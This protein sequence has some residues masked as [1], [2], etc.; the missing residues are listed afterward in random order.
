MH[1]FALKTSED[2]LKLDLEARGSF[3][4]VGYG[5]LPNTGRWKHGTG[6]YELCLAMPAA[7]K[8]SGK[9]PHG[10]HV[11]GMGRNLKVQVSCLAS[12]KFQK[13][14]EDFC[15]LGKEQ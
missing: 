11:L 13:S 15:S 1:M 14:V 7:G 2:P 8:H 4:E 10:I 6:H 9:L 5:L 3:D 12:H